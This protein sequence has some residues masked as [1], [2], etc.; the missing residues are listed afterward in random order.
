MCILNICKICTAIKSHAK[1]KTRAITQ[2]TH[3]QFRP[4]F[5][6]TLTLIY[7]YTGIIL[8]KVLTLQRA[9][10]GSKL[11]S[12]GETRVAMHKA[13]VSLSPLTRAPCSETN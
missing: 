3:F 8:Q 13:L 11:V 6:A 5:E 9:L 10:K 12:D 7:I 2:S 1:T 4:T